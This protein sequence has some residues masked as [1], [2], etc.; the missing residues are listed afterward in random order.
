MIL[1]EHHCLVAQFINV[2]QITLFSDVLVNYVLIPLVDVATSAYCL[3]LK[4]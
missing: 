1:E 2:F 4:Y 3:F